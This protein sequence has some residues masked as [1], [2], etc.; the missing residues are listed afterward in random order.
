MTNRGGL[1]TNGFSNH[2]LWYTDCED[3][4]ATK[5]HLEDRNIPYRYVNIDFDAEAERFVLFINAGQRITPT[6][7]FD[8]GKLKFVM[9]EPTLAEVDEL[10]PRRA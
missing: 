9:S 2:S 7:V 6:I 1:I 3:T 4:A 8:G 5:V 10:L